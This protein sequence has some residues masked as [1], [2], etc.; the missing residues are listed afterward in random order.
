MNT[1][2]MDLKGQIKKL[3]SDQTSQKKEI[4]EQKKKLGNCVR[5]VDFYNTSS[6]TYNMQTKYFYLF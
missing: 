4:A 5:T 3:S 6:I 1:I 2:N